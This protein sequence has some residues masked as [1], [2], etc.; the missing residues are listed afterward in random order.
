MSLP[1]IYEH[2][3]LY[4]IFAKKSLGQNFLFDSNITDK[5]VEH[6]GDLRGKDVIEIGPG[7]GGL[8]RSIL[9]ANPRKLVVIEKDSRCIAL[10]NEVKS[11][12]PN[13]TI[14]EEDALK[15][16]L[17]SIV[18]DKPKVISNLPYNIGTELLCRWIDQIA[19]FSDFTLMFQRE[20]AMRICSM[21]N[22]SHYGRLSL[23]VSLLAKANRCFD[24]SPE[25][26]TPAPKV[27]SSVV[28]IIPKEVSYSQ[29]F[30]QNFTKIVK[31]AFS[32]RRK[33]IKKNLSELFS[34]EELI[35]L[36]VDPKLRAEN[37]S[38]EDYIRL[39]KNYYCK[40]FNQ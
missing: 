30:I 11:Y 16:D 15:L 4:E 29:K 20:V 37:L 6:S 13:L 27:T 12:Y 24:I 3:K 21:E 33:M 18:L 22:D 34:E 2:A 23:M 8:T 1:S 26:F 40:N 35:R 31:Q 28:K 7:P 25:A 19:H 32:A 9:E 39:T 5:I 14:I 38:L 36:D 17:S 10:L